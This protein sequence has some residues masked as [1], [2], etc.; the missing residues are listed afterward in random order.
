[1]KRVLVTGA[2]G[3]IGTIVVPILRDHYEVTTLDR[4]GGRGQDLR[5]PGSI[6]DAFAAQDAVIHLAFSPGSWDDVWANDLPA[7]CN[8]LAASVASG[9]PRVIVASSNHVTGG[10]ERD[11]P[12]SDIVAGRYGSLEP[13]AVPKI[14]IDWEERPDSP[15]AVAKLAVEAAA[16]HYA[17]DYDL[18]VLALRIG[19][20]NRE[21]R[22][23]TLRH[24]ATLLSH[25]DLTTLL[26]RG[27][28]AELAD[29]FALHYAASPNRW[30]YWDIDSTRQALSWEPQDDAEHWREEA[31]W[32][33]RDAVRPTAD[34]SFPTTSVVIATHD[35]REQ[36]AATV[37]AIL[38]DPTTS[39]V[40][41]VDDGGQDGTLQ[42][43]QA[44]AN[45]DKRL[46]PVSIENRGQYGALQFGVGMAQGDVVLLLDDDIVALPGLVRGHAR[47]HA[48]QTGLVVVG[49]SPVELP[50]YRRRGE[51]PIHLYREDYERQCGQWEQD[52]SGVLT[53]LWGTNVSIG[54]D[55]CLR[56]GLVGPVTDAR[57]HNDDRDF[58]H[59]CLSAGLTGVFDRSLRARHIHRRSVNTLLSTEAEA[60]AEGA[61]DRH[62]RNTEAAGPLRLDGYEAGLPRPAQWTVRA[63]RI[64][65]VNA[66]EAALLRPVIAVAG[67][68]KL[69]RVER[70]A[71]LVALHLREMS[72][73]RTMA[74]T[75]APS[76]T[77]STVDGEGPDHRPPVDP[78]C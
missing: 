41:V 37:D 30:C 64:A 12:Y 76:D 7:T 71:T 59:R 57:R 35:R 70:L 1:M 53:S 54:R 51:A 56:V 45:S 61:W 24:F 62:L 17:D 26:L 36:V 63:G 28:E 13:A 43:L 74:R 67:L 47:R 4:A 49:Y 77:V 10:Y 68:V 8:V 42:R 31:R 14:G 65:P 44:R 52:P 66:V 2:A 9:I 19:T 29:T 33:Q 22:P 5:R 11:A 40:I 46:R 39:E 58:G 73:L 55:D 60:R 15:Y 23:T 6:A 69:W 75:R 32:A 34:R 18:S 16:R 3:L 72:V 48:E 38:A 20:V 21:D 27:I 78:T 25:R 50:P